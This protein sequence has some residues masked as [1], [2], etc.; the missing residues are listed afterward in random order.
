MSDECTKPIEFIVPPTIIRWEREDC[1][2]ELRGWFGLGL[3]SLFVERQG[4]I[5]HE[6]PIP[7]W[8]MAP[9]GGKI[10]NACQLLFK[11]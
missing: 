11:A 2:L 9:L 5:P 7:D 6:L 10:I 1:V 3:L 4:E 8:A